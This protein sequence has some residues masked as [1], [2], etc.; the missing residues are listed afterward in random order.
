MAMPAR[1]RTVALALERLEWDP[2]EFLVS[3][4]RDPR[5]NINLACDISK[6]LL[7]Y[8]YARKSENVIE[9][10]AVT[11][12]HTSTICGI[13]TAELMKNRELRRL[14]ENTQI[15]LDA[16]KRRLRRIEE[17]T[18]ARIIDTEALPE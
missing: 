2:L 3:V 18:P 6:E 4:A 5:C 16:E 12:E 9:L 17:A 7:R 1:K 13:P 11:V 10:E 8:I 14:I 15:Q